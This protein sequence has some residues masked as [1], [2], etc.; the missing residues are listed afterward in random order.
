MLPAGVT[1]FQMMITHFGGEP[2]ELR[3]F[4]TY[5]RDYVMNAGAGAPSMVSMDFVR[6]LS[7]DVQPMLFQVELTGQDADPGH[8]VG[9]VVRGDASFAFDPCPA[10]TEEYGAG[11]NGRHGVP[12]LGTDAPPV[13]GT[14]MSFE[15]GNSLLEDTSG[16][17][18]VGFQKNEAPTAFGGT[19]NVKPALVIPVALPK[20]GFSFPYAVPTDPSLCG[21][22]FFHQLFVVDEDASDGLSFSRGLQ[23]TIGN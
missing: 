15:L 5:G 7:S 21:V 23:V 9:L 16:F 12:T 8:F 10:R 17:W 19:L 14:T 6:D 13:V 3:I 4:E 1:S 11:W 22:S 2:A 20:Q 18:A